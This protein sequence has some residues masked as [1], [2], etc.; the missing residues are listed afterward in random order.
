M[1]RLIIAAASLLAAAI[2][3]PVLAAEVTAGTLTLQQAWARAS[4]GP[5]KAG[6]AYLT[7]VNRGAEADRLLAVATPVAKVAQLHTNLMK[8]GIMRMRRVEVL[9]IAPGEPVVLRPGGLHV[10]LMGLK[11][12]LIEGEDFPLL[13][14]FEKAGRIEIPVRIEAP[15]AMEPAADS[16]VPGDHVQ[17][18]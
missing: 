2:C 11:K 8:D 18:S 15:N 4:I 1:T 12:K 3:G 9:E 6:A 5:A 14:T 7:I 13:L 10:M 16:S 17:G